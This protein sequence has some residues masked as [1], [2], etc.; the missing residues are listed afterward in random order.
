MRIMDVGS[1]ARATFKSSDK[2]EPEDNPT[3]EKIAANNGITFKKN[4][5]IFLPF[6][7]F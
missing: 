3:I 7:L 5:F 2:T 1:A 4:F 6:N